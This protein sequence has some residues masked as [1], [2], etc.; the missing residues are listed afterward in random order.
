MKWE[1]LIMILL[2]FFLIGLVF[3][4]TAPAQERQILVTMTC[5]EPVIPYASSAMVIYLN[6]LDNAQVKQKIYPIVLKSIGLVPN[7][8]GV[9]LR[10]DGSPYNI[11]GYT[12]WDGMIPE[13]YLNSWKTARLIAYWNCFTDLAGNVSEKNIVTNSFILDATSPKVIEL[14][15]TR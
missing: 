8:T 5:S 2:F 15:V 7:A 10:T 13:L 6:P 4:L 9:R 14:L 11:Y 3:V 1:Y 12:M